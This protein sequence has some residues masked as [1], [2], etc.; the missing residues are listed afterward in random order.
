[1]RRPEY[2]FQEANSKRGVDSPVVLTDLS[3]WTTR[4]TFYSSVQH[5]FL[6]AEAHSCL[7]YLIMYLCKTA[8]FFSE[9]KAGIF[10]FLVI[11]KGLKDALITTI[12]TNF[13]QSVDHRNPDIVRLIRKASQNYYQKVTYAIFWLFHFFF[14]LFLIL[15]V[16]VEYGGACNEEKRQISN[17]TGSKWVTGL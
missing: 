16:K 12:L 5:Y 2:L 7:P 9:M 4:A 6:A 15:K 17:G 11:R 8:S 1:M 10:L 3:F 14:H 13:S